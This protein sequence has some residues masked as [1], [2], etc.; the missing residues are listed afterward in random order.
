MV[1][2]WEGGYG[3]LKGENNRG[4]EG[5]RKKSLLPGAWLNRINKFVNK[6]LT[7]YFATIDNRYYLCGTKAKKNQLNNIKKNKYAI[8]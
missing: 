2:G 8:H 1:D 7:F 3:S 4:E 5:L 6:I